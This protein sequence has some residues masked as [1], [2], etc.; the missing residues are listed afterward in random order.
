MKNLIYNFLFKNS[1]FY[2]TFNKKKNLIKEYEVYNCIDKNM[3]SYL[4][5]ACIKYSLGYKYV[6]VASD[7]LFNISAEYTLENGKDFFKTYKVDEFT[8]FFKSVLY[9]Y[10]RDIFIL[11][12]QNKFLIKKK[13]A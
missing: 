7:L 9:I 11:K 10:K 3:D 2:K 13:A 8:S 1:D 4:Y 5:E 6:T 12:I